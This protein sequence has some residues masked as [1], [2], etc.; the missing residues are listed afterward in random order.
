MQT[1]ELTLSFLG[2]VHIY[3]DGQDLTQSLPTKAQALLCY[4]VLSRRTLQRQEIVGM[5]W[6]DSTEARARTSLRV[7]LRRMNE[8]GLEP[9]L[10]PT[11]ANLTFLFHENYQCDV[12]AFE[13]LMVTANANS[14]Q[15]NMLI[16]RQAMDLYHGDFLLG[17]GV[18]D[19][20]EF[21][22]WMLAQRERLR[23][24]ALNGL[25]SLI[26][27]FVE[28]NQLSL[29]IEYAHRLLEL[30]PWRESA[31]RQLMWLFASN[32]Q[33]AAALTQYEKCRELL[34]NEL[35]LEP[36]QETVLLAEEIQNEFQTATR[37]LIP[38]PPL[39]KEEELSTTTPF[40][41]PERNPCFVGRKRS[42]ARLVH[43][44]LDENHES[45]FCVTGMGGVGKT[46][47]LIELAHQLKD[48][49]TDGVLWA[50]AVSADVIDIAEKWANAY[51]YD[52]TALPTFA[53]QTFAL[54]NL[55]ATK[56]ALLVV[57]DVA[58]AS[59]IRPLLPESGHSIVLMSSR[60]A[61]VAHRLRARQ[62]H[63]AEFTPTE[64]AALLATHIGEFRIQQESEATQEICALVG[65]LPLAIALIGGYLNHRPYRSLNQ[66]I[67]QLEFDLNQLPLHLREVGLHRSME[68]SWQSLDETQKQVFCAVTV[69]SGR[70]FS[71]QAIAFVSDLDV[72]QAEDRLEDLIRFSLLK[73]DTPFRYR[74]HR[75]LMEFAQEKTRDS[76]ALYRRMAQYYL[77]F[78]IE[79][80]TDYLA[81]L[82]E[83]ENIDA[84]I[85][86]AYAHQKWEMVLQFTA[87]LQDVWFA[88]GRYTEA[89]RAFSFA[90]SAAMALENEQALAQ[91]L[92]LS[93][94]ASLEQS[95]FVEASEKLTKSLTLYQGLVDTEGVGN[96]QLMLS[97][98]ALVRGDY[99]SAEQLLLDSQQS[100]EQVADVAALATIQY[101]LARL[102]NSLG[103]YEQA[104][105]I[106]ETAVSLYHNIPNKE[107]LIPILRLDALILLNRKQ[108]DAAK[109]QAEKA[110]R[111]AEEN[112]SKS[113]KAVTLSNLASIERNLRNF[114]QALQYI[115]DSLE[116]LELIGDRRSRA[117]AIY[118]QMLIYR[119]MEQIEAL[120]DAGAT[121]LNM[122]REF[123][124]LRHV[125][126]TLTHMGNGYELL[127]DMDTAVHYWQE[128]LDIAQTIEH[129]KLLP[130]LQEKLE[131]EL[132]KE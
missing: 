53:E 49:F 6:G 65:Q 98:L 22:V 77:Q 56:N 72:Y 123:A 63:L 58:T 29:G 61:D 130:I 104:Q 14:D 90:E 118:R 5:F 51:G 40:Q 16:L 82:P 68:I 110:L 105:Q 73:K 92:F 116:I 129:A 112:H 85:R 45:R 47:V 71:L 57:D 17:F 23:Q 2:G 95:D 101:Q 10:N 8:Q 108:F 75:L 79:K 121:C 3:L 21:D 80:Q 113:E 78:A 86:F 120:L 12:E 18:S 106:C 114:D 107:G 126:L 99:K 81:F 36:D 46:T 9:Y 87:V 62:L 109:E 131:H 74:Q 43:L 26:A 41:A 117:V 44:I 15:V 88:R 93:G 83:W 119:D 67:D 25:D 103:R 102:A 39:R 30:D 37:P 122:F 60:Q 76:I 66:F 11:R 96:V 91:N 55:L 111:L 24:M 69:F 4:A 128:A 52:F 13:Q 33:R 59:A 32:G 20:P 70:D 35:G 84:A 127:G 7:A 132:S 1:N 38:L 28:Q 64:S 125:A 19:S 42:L 31:H 94:Q 89:R 34:L 97:R 27:D 115:D 124:D 48:Y 50:T 54:R 100:A